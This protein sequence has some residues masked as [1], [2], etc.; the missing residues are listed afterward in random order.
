MFLPCQ[1]LV[2]LAFIDYMIYIFYLKKY[3][4]LYNNDIYKYRIIIRTIIWLLILLLKNNNHLCISCIVFLI[5]IIENIYFRNNF[6]N[7]INFI[8]ADII[9]SIIYLNIIIHI[10]QYI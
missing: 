3:N 9:L 8:V 2:I 10:S 7:N 1:I 6:N 4:I 5:Y